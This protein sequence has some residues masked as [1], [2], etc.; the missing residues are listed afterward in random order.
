MEQYLIKGII[1][2]EEKM[3]SDRNDALFYAQRLIEQG[4]KTIILDTREV[5]RATQEED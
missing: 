5:I 2:H 3:F 4:V 1:T